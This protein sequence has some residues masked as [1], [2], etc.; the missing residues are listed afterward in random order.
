MKIVHI[1]F[2]AAIVVGCSHQQSTSYYQTKINEIS[3]VY[4]PVENMAAA[5]NVAGFYPGLS[6]KTELETL[7]SKYTAYELNQRTILIDTLEDYRNRNVNDIRKIEDARNQLINNNSFSGCIGAQ[8]HNCIAGISLE[9]VVSTSPYGDIISMPKKDIL[10]KSKHD[11]I[12]FGGDIYTLG[13]IESGWDKS[14]WDASMSEIK[15]GREMFMRD[16]IGVT[17]HANGGGSVSSIVVHLQNSGLVSS[18]TEDQFRRTKVYDVFKAISGKKCTIAERDFYSKIYMDLARNGSGTSDQF[19][20]NFDSISRVQATDFRSK[21]RICG[22]MT[23]FS[24]RRHRS[25]SV[26]H[27]AETDNYDL[28]IG[29]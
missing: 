9:M 20:N 12:I 21:V 23:S 24:I 2:A 28:W 7:G 25:A 29:K 22:L 6:A 5:M 10:G 18:I 14:G 1:C 26:S 16:K 8:I 27:Y 15:S 3:S 11:S 13:K 4:V 19:Y 17:V